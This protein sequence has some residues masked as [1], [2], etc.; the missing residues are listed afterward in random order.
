MKEG[1]NAIVS[2][3]YVRSVE[4]NLNVD[5]SGLDY[6][7][8]AFEVL[9]ELYAQLYDLHSDGLWTGLL[10]DNASFEGPAD[11][12]TLHSPNRDS[13]VR[14]AFLLGVIVW[15]PSVSHTLPHPYACVEQES[16]ALD[17]GL[18]PARIR[19]I[20]GPD[21]GDSAA[22]VRLADLVGTTCDGD[23]EDVVYLADTLGL[24]ETIELNADGSVQAVQ[25][26]AA[27]ADDEPIATRICRVDA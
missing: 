21:G 24:V 8:Q 7:T 10:L 4:K 27:A 22:T 5:L 1:W 6:N 26:Y 18:T 20:L 14:A 9:S 12:P 25:L 17:A 3:G 16:A 2:P 15:Y 19:E 11:G 13:W 23:V